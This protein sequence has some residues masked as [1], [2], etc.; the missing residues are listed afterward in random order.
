MAE[1]PTKKM[2]V[3]DALFVDTFD[4]VPPATFVPASAVLTEQEEHRLKKSC[5]HYNIDR[6][7]RISEHILNAIIHYYQIQPLPTDTPHIK[8]AMHA[9]V[10]QHL[11]GVD[12]TLRNAPPHPTDFYYDLLCIDIHQL[13]QPTLA[14]PRRRWMISCQAMQNNQLTSI[15]YAE[16]YP[17]VPTDGTMLNLFDMFQQDVDSIIFAGDRAELLN[18]DPEMSIVGARNFCLKDL[19]RFQHRP[20]CLS[21]IP[22]VAVLNIV[23]DLIGNGT[24]NALDTFMVLL[25]QNKSIGWWNGHVPLIC[26]ALA[27]E[28]FEFVLALLPYTNVHRVWLRDDVTNLSCNEDA[29]VLNQF[30]G[31]STQEIL[32]DMTGVDGKYSYLNEYF[33]N[34][35][36]LPEVASVGGGG[37]GS[38]GGGSNSS[39]S[40]SSSTAGQ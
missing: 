15:F 18:Q 26:F 21:F 33:K 28:R 29:T 37:S 14:F 4:S 9:R 40:S 8:H 3:G 6:I 34:W 38:G 5:A 24:V 11:Q 13:D 16:N 35:M 22:L 39:S 7:K 19:L 23:L 31:R 25:C 10:V 20:L 2:R 30:V 36:R 17:Y 27:W 32:I 1:R 12:R